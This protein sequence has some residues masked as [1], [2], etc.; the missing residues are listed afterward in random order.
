MTSGMP[1]HF[2]HQIGRK[3][4]ELEALREYPLA[5]LAD[6]LRDVGFSCNCCA[7]CCTRAFNGHVL[8]MEEDCERIISIDPSAIEPPPV[9]DFCDQHGIFYVSGFTIKAREG[10][11]GPCHF[12]EGRRCRIYQARPRVC[13]IYPYMLHREPDPDGVVD[14][15]Q[16]SGLNEH[17]EYH[18]DISE[19]EADAIV[20][21]VLSFEEAVITEEIAFLE[22]TA[23]YFQAHGLRHVRKRY[24]DGTRALQKGNAATVLVYF[25]GSF[26]EW[27]VQG[28]K[29]HPA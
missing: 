8:L 21:D 1:A 23:R 15:R 17:G 3:R 26:K 22:Y 25:G 5:L 13:R 27:I 29:M 2:I 20:R 28:G 4:E 16:I 11:E 7:K 19:E 18:S 24:D 6:I 14:W 12:L 10:V 9:F